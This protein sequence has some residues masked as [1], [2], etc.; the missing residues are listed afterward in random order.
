MAEADTYGKAL[1][2]SED[3]KLLSNIL[4]RCNPPLPANKQQDTTRYAALMAWSII[5]K[6]EQAYEAIVSALASGAGLADCL[7]AAEAA[8]ASQE[9]VL[10]AA[11]VARAEAIANESPQQKAARER[12]EMAARGRF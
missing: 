11:A 1:G 3:L 5:K 12:E 8:E 2:A 6:H 7:K 9:D 10:K 4:A